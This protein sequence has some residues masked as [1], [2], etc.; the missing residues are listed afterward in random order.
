MSSKKQQKTPR[1]RQPREQEIVAHRR[2]FL[3]VA[4]GVTATVGV[5][6]TAYPFVASLLPS[7]KA[8]AKGGPVTV[9][10]GGIKPG[11]QLTVIWRGKPVWVLHRTEHEIRELSSPALQSELRDPDSSESQQPDYARNTNRSRRPEYFVC[12]ASCTHL[13]CVPQL[14]GDEEPGSAG[15]KPRAGYFCPCH[16]S[17]FDLAGRVFRGVPAPTNLVVPPYRYLKNGKLQIG[18]DSA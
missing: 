12:I 14:L 3:Q 17:K 5:A 4:T 1:S 6:A 18:K 11:E 8:R 10:P 15:G 9:E 2:H 13:G 7:A 16:G